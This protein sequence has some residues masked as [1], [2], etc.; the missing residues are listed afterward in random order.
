[1]LRSSMKVNGRRD[2]EDGREV[3]EM[4]R[5]WLGSRLYPTNRSHIIDNSP[6]FLLPQ[7]HMDSLAKKH[8]RRDVCGQFSRYTRKGTMRCTMG[9]A[10]SLTA[11]NTLR[12]R[13]F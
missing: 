8:N 13:T 4:I 10:A 12:K 5:A 3:R 11:L 6:R 1:M 2:K 7:L 9:R